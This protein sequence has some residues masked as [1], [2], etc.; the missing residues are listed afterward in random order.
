MD[1]FRIVSFFGLSR[2]PFGAF[3]APD[4]VPKGIE[5]PSKKR[6]ASDIFSASLFGFFKAPIRRPWEPNCS[7]WAPLEP[8]KEEC[9]GS[10]LG[11]PQMVPKS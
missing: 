1:L 2:P 9:P 10:A 8:P 7:H 6:P 5:M 11:G 3:E 4:V